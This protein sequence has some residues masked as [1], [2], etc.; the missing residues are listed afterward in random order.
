MVTI[1]TRLTELG[2]SLDELYLGE[3]KQIN[4]KVDNSPYT[5]HVILKGR[6]GNP[7]CKLSSFSANLWFRTPR[8]VTSTKYKQLSILQRELIR[9]LESKIEIKGA[10][11]F[12]ISNVV[13]TI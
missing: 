3:T 7:D 12:S 8:G 2:V 6:D 1:G 11:H 4:I 13:L 10:I 5:W 9:A